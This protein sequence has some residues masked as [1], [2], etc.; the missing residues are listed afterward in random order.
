MPNQDT[1][2]ATALY[3]NNE[4]SEKLEKKN[5]ILISFKKEREHLEVNLNKL[6]TAQ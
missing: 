6:I 3:T 1:N 5:P 4:P 2:L